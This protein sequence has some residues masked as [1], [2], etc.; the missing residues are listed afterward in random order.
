MVDEQR[1]GSSPLMIR[2]TSHY[3]SEY[4]E[5]FVEHWDEVANWEIR[6]EYEKDYYNNILKNGRCEYVLD[7]ATG[8]GY[9]SVKLTTLGY[10]VTSL[11][12][13]TTMLKKAVSNGLKKGIVLNTISCDWQNISSSILPHE[14]DAVICLGNSFTHVFESSE[15]IKILK[16]FRS[17]LKPNGILIIDHRNYDSIVKGIPTK[18]AQYYAGVSATAEPE[19]I[20]NGL[21]RYKYKF[22]DGTCYYLNMFPITRDVLIAEALEAGFNLEHTL[23]DLKEVNTKDAAFVQHIFRSFQ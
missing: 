17:T 5:N 6:D 13:C 7:V 20:D 21:A 9:H 12:G 16:K 3:L 4:T 2:D 19:Y 22:K 18:R 11:D 8:T 14:Y 10:K 15:R 23:H 1:F